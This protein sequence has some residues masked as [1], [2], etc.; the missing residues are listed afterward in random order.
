MRTSSSSSEEDFDPDSSFTA[1]AARSMN[2]FAKAEAAEAAGSQEAGRLYAV[3]AQELLAAAAG[4]PQQQQLVQVLEDR[5]A[6]AT[7]RA[8]AAVQDLSPPQSRVAYQEALDSSE[9]GSALDDSDA[10]FLTI[11]EARPERL[12]PPRPAALSLWVPPRPGPRS[13]L[14]NLRPDV[15]ERVN[16]GGEARWA[17]VQLERLFPMCRT[18]IGE[19]VLALPPC[20]RGDR[21][22]DVNTGACLGRAAAAVLDAY[23]SAAMALQDSDE[24]RLEV[25]AERLSKAGHGEA[26]QRLTLASGLAS[27]KDAPNAGYTLAISAMGLSRGLAC[28]SHMGAAALQPTAADKQQ[29]TAAY[30]PILQAVLES[31]VRFS[32]TDISA[33]CCPHLTTSVLCRFPVGTLSSRSGQ[34]CCRPLTTSGCSRGSGLWRWMWRGSGKG[35]SCAAGGGPRAEKLAQCHECT[36]IC[37]GTG[38]TRLAS[39]PCYA[40]CEPCAS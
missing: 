32:A 39:Q 35:L 9:G 16:S 17:D 2:A 27:G 38:I 34:R 4:I 28:E 5:A 7:Q 37:I 36:I 11:P 33:L 30:E 25:A 1:A 22:L 8:D 24:A 29:L 18:M 21:V 10:S 19:L 14:Q 20:G 15:A 23:P 3:A 40:A 6:L 13:W 26:D 31:L 12:L